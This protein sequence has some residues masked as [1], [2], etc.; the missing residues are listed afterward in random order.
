MEYRREL[1]SYLLGLLLALVLTA[2]PFALVYRPAIPR[3]WILIA[4][5]ALALLQ[6]VVHFRFFLHIDPP[7]QRLDDLHLLLFSALIVLL[8]AG[9]TVWILSNLAERMQ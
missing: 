8:M 5:G 9:G 2:V 4:I 3:S 6:I 7:R 1:R